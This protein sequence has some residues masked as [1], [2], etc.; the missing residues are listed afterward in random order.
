[1]HHLFNHMGASPRMMTPDWLQRFNAAAWVGSN[2]LIIYI[3]L[4]LI[5]F[6][7][8]YF[9]WFDPFSTAAGKMVLQFVIS[10]LGV[11]FLIAI[12]LFV[13]P[14]EGRAWFQYPGDVLWWRPLLR[15]LFYA[16]VAYT[17]TSLCVLL[18]VRKHHPERIKIAPDIVQ[19]RKK[20]KQK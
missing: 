14:S 17:S 10:L 15:I 19:E 9:R 6:V 18:Y 13:N 1:M 12:S 16:A 20:K 8:F 3:G 4:A 5:L 11:M 2:L 7:F